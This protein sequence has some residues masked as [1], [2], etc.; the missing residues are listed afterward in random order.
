[1]HRRR[2]LIFFLVGSKARERAAKLQRWRGRQ[3]PW[4]DARPRRE[5][6]VGAVPGGADQGT[7]GDGVS[8]LLLADVRW[9]P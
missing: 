5:A 1:M 8:L 2:C 9:L 4:L 3:L 7:A 6:A